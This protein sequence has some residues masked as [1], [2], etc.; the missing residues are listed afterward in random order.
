MSPVILYVFRKDN[1]GAETI[2]K[3]Y[4]DSSSSSIYTKDFIKNRNWW[5][6]FWI[7]L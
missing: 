4:D 6:V 2:R 3:K 5:R 1:N 7:F